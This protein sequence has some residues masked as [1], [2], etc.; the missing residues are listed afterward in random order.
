[1]EGVGERALFDASVLVGVGVAASGLLG[2][3]EVGVE[4]V[5]G[6][7][8][9]AGVKVGVSEAVAVGLPPSLCRISDASLREMARTY[10]IQSWARGSPL[11][12]KRSTSFNPKKS[13]DTSLVRETL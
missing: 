5:V 1:V 12:G 7:A 4:S 8:A 10:R 9:S 3:V 11:Y 13:S 6:V 2:S